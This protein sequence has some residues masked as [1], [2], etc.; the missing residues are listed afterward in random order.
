MRVTLASE[1]APGRPANEDHAFRAGD[2]V[3]VLDGVTNPPGM[4]SGCVHGPAWYVRRLA[5]HLA[6]TAADPAAPLTDGL[7]AAIEATREDHGGGCDLGHPNTP[8]ATV[9]LLR[10][11]GDRAE[12]LVLSDALAVLEVGDR[13]QVVTDERYT[14]AVA[15]IRQL[16]MAGAPPIGSAEHEQRVRQT[17]TMR[18]ERTNRPGGYWIAAAAPA[19]AY[20]AVTSSVPLTGPGRLRRAALLTDGA[21]CAVDSYGLLG[22]PG[23][24]DLLDRQGP[25]E[26]IRRVREFELADGTGAARP[27][28]KRHD[29]ATA[30]FCR[31]DR[32]EGEPG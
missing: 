10:V 24:L 31:F 18:Q 20:E 26:L 13:V 30:A 12:Y 3:G 22:W 14:A 1:P 25:A 21:S 9:A 16:V 4:E 7:A 17:V 5:D 15:D 2:L 11:D 27:R 29:D 32:Q 19:A 28:Y 23:L 6:R 8:A